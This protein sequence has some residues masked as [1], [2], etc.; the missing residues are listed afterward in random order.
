MRV[1]LGYMLRSMRLIPGAKH[2]DLRKMTLRL[3]KNKTKKNNNYYYNNDKV[4]NDISHDAKQSTQSFQ[5]QNKYG[6]LPL[7][8]AVTRTS[9]FPSIS[10]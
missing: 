3:K 4:V 8:L 6:T 9:R 1:C 2:R 5:K 10:C 7:K